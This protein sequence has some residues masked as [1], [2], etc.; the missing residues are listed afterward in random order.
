MIQA[1]HRNDVRFSSRK[2][3]GIISVAEVV[4]WFCWIFLRF[5]LK[6]WLPKKCFTN[7]NA[8]ASP[9]KKSQ[10]AVKEITVRLFAKLFPAFENA[11]TISIAPYT[12]AFPAGKQTIPRSAVRSK[13]NDPFIV[14]IQF[15]ILEYLSSPKSCCFFVCLRLNWGSWYI[16]YFRRH[17]KFSAHT[18][19]SEAGRCDRPG[20]FLSDCSNNWIID[21]VERPFIGIF[22]VPR[23]LRLSPSFVGPCCR[24]R[25]IYRILMSYE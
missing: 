3:S 18:L 19:S 6:D 1:L 9:N 2:T 16:Y 14:S 23:L 10:D 4:V 8:S 13:F 12:L 20:I 15:V 5:S 22:S 21:S 7:T 11:K 17:V 24:F 25:F